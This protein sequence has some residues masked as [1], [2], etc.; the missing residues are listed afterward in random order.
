[1][2]KTSYQK[3]V[4]FS[5]DFGKKNRLETRGGAMK[6]AGTKFTVDRLKEWKVPV[7]NTPIPELWSE[8]TI[9]L[10]EA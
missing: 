3:Y 10:I 9:E 5:I 4:T 6:S 7:I 1:M 2:R 8:V